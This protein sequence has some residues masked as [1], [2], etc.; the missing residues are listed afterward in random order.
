MA[1]RKSKKRI[2][3]TKPEFSGVDELFS[4]NNIDG[5]P[6]IPIKNNDD[7]GKGSYL[8]PD[9]ERPENT[10]LLQPMD[11]PYNPLEKR[12][13]QMPISVDRTMSAHDLHYNRARPKTVQDLARLVKPASG[14]ELSYNEAVLLES[15]GLLDGT[16]K[17][18]KQFRQD[19]QAR[20]ANEAMIGKFGL[21]NPIDMLFGSETK[22]GKNIPGLFD[23]FDVVAET[24]GAFSAEQLNKLYEATVG[25][26]VANTIPLAD[27]LANGGMSPEDFFNFANYIGTTQQENI[28]NIEVRNKESEQLLTD[29]ITGQS[30]LTTDETVNAITNNFNDR[31][32][33]EQLLVSFLS[34]ENFIPVGGTTKASITGAAMLGTKFGPALAK[35]GLP[36]LGLAVAKTGSVAS[37]K[38]PAPVY[39][40]KDESLK[41]IEKIF[42]TIK[43][44]PPQLSPTIRD[45]FIKLTN[46]LDEVVIKGF[47]NKR[48]Y[49]H[50]NTN[51]VKNNYRDLHGNELPPELDVAMQIQL[52]PGSDS[53]ILAQTQDVINKVFKIVDEEK[54][55]LEHINAYLLMKHMQDTLRMHPQRITTA[56]KDLTKWLE[57]I[58]MSPAD[59]EPVDEL[60]DYNQNLDL[61][62]KEFEKELGE[63]LF[64]KVQRGARLI[65]NAMDGKLQEAVDKGITNGNEVAKLRKQYPWYHPTYYLDVL[66]DAVDGFDEFLPRGNSISTAGD[67]VG[68]LS[69]K[70]RDAPRALPIDAFIRYMARQDYF[71]QTNDI[72]RKFIA[73][74]AFFPETGQ[75][76]GLIDEASH[77]YTTIRD[78]GKV[79]PIVQPKKVVEFVTDAKGKTKKIE[80]A[81]VPRSEQGKLEYTENYRRIAKK[82]NEV[83]FLANGGKAYTYQVSPRAKREFDNLMGMGQPNMMSK[84]FT[85]LVRDNKL[86]DLMRGVWIQYNP[87]VLTAL[88]VADITTVMFTRG[89]P[90][91]LKQLLYNPNDEATIINSYY[92]AWKSVFTEDEAMQGLIANRGDVMG[93]FG[94]SPEQIYKDHIKNMKKGESTANTLVIDRS[95]RKR[96]LDPRNLPNTIRK[97]THA[98][99]MAPRLAVYRTEIAQ[100]ADPMVAAIQ[101]RNAT[102]DFQQIG[103]AMGLINTPFWF[104]NAGL[105]GILAPVKAVQRNPRV[106]AKG[107][108]QFVG[109]EMLLYQWN[110]QFE[111]YQ[112]V[113]L[114]EQRG[115]YISLPSSEYDNNGRKVPHGLLIPNYFGYVSSPLRYGMKQVDQQMADIYPDLFKPNTTVNAN[116]YT[117]ALV[118]GAGALNPFSAITGRATG[119]TPTGFFSGDAKLIGAS[120]TPTILTPFAEV[121]ANVNSFTGRPIVPTRL[122]G[123]A[124]EDQYDEFITSDAAKRLGKMFNYSPMKIDHLLDIGGVP[125]DLFIYV[126]QKLRP[127][128]SNIVF[129][130]SQYEVMIE[131]TPPDQ[132]QIK[133]KEFINNIEMDGKTKAENIELRNKFEEYLRRKPAIER[134]DGVPVLSWFKNRFINQRGGAM[135]EGGLEKA[136]KTVKGVRINPITKEKEEYDIDIKQ[137]L[138][139]SKRAALIYNMHV[140]PKIHELNRGLDLYRANPTS[141]G[142]ISPSQW[143]QARKD[144]RIFFNSQLEAIVHPQVGSVLTEGGSLPFAAQASLIRENPETGELTNVYLEWLDVVNTYG[145][146]IESPMDKG[147]YFVSAFYGLPVYDINGKLLDGSES[148]T[149]I[150]YG[151]L[152]RDQESFINSLS[153][154]DKKAYDDW[155]A[156]TGTQT[157]QEYRQA[158]EIMSPYYGVHDTEMQWMNKN[159]DLYPDQNGILRNFEWHHNQWLLT[160]GTEQEVKEESYTPTINGRPTKGISYFN[161]RVRNIRNVIFRNQ[162][163]ENNIVGIQ[164][165][166]RWVGGD[167]SDVITRHAKSLN[168]PDQEKGNDGYLVATQANINHYL[169]IMP[170]IERTLLNWGRISKPQNLELFQD[171]QQNEVPRLLEQFGGVSTPQ[172]QQQQEFNIADLLKPRR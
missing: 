120:V 33:A 107:M 90:L 74:N 32:F 103:S 125:N 55:N 70:G 75:V 14:S 153:K 66:E 149:N 18:P 93:L 169:T 1:E 67:L 36:A 113:P 39:K 84:A 73:E 51:E 27:Y 165:N 35:A 29:L 80:K 24:G 68:S 59:V 69:E 3:V 163:P 155:L 100:G 56:P 106:L 132:I 159:V 87:V 112:D 11:V 164:G 139:Y 63:E 20:E 40:Y 17:L 95:S 15:L 150:D 49:W 31:K 122:Q 45:P 43:F 9:F 124:A 162:N 72:K 151:R 114:S 91:G 133:T 126:D 108:G 171:I 148:N 16:Y 101:A 86:A 62:L 130:D 7:T 131:S 10:G 76:I 53:A 38:I 166:Y 136:Q 142:A 47:V 98:T 118:E 170:K 135:W 79:R 2:K 41:R 52:L 34:P 129:L 127:E 83:T 109:L 13:P 99:E 81:G 145:G 4:G 12:K 89:V 123:L 154:K 111:E 94:R 46:T 28:E 61:A 117:D 146:L 37:S 25:P 22:S 147:A 65:V 88:G 78:P 23:Y 167:I 82:E 104:V 156:V 92:K 8:S 143:E 60:L 6:Y 115:F 97:L 96:F 152:N 71:I 144:L 30:E 140:E 102:G 116:T 77:L 121:F 105:Q 26:A 50:R 54:I 119:I 85:K 57:S 157:E 137:T 21:K 19:L 5:E 158:Q 110:R 160:D 42:N 161:S 141:E 48:R 128:D 44:S 64:D 138:E 134:R 168:F 58:Y 172:Q